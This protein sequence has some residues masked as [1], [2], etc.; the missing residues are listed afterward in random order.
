MDLTELLE[1]IARGE[2]SRHQFK[3]DLHSPDQLAAELVA[4][5]NSAGG[6]L[7]IGVEDDGSLSGLDSTAVSRIN[8]LLSNTASQGVRPPINPLTSNIATASGVVIAVQITPGVNRPY[9]DKDGR[10]WVKNGADKRHVT[11]IEELRRMFQA[12]DLIYADETPIAGSTLAHLDARR[13]TTYY[14]RR[15]S[16]TTER[17]GVP[18]TRLLANLQLATENGQ[19]NRAGLLMFGSI[20]QQFLP[21][22][23]IKAVAF[24]GTD[25]RDT[26]YDESVDLAGTLVDQYTSAMAFLRR[27]LRSV[28]AD[29]NF[30]STGELEIPPEVLQEILVNALVHRDYFINAPIRLLMLADRLEVISPGHLPNHLTVEN[31]RH[32]ISNVRNPVIFSHATQLLPYRGLGSGISRS[33]KLHPH[34]DFLDQREAQQFTVIIYRTTF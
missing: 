2:D 23:M 21:T 1:V 27:N 4:F 34:I 33:L 22:A 17:S 14:E 29:Q 10:I 20:P 9:T 30:N 13:F 18:M 16:E 31:I 5:S 26:V 25:W 7:L 6:V 15:Y 19:L 28:Q 12:A 3:R 24:P 32:G 8:Q 11:A